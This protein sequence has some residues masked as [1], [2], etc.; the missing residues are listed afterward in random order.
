MADAPEESEGKAASLV[1]ALPAAPKTDRSLGPVDALSAYMAQLA[2]YP[3]VSREE[4]QQLALRWVEHGD[5]EAA[6]RL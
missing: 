2:H 5:I 1:P 6:R 4:E 3:P